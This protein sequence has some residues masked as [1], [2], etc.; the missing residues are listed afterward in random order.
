MDILDY[1]HWRGD[2]TFDERPY[3]EVDSLAFCAL[4][5]EVL[6]DVFVDKKELTL[7][8]AAVLFFA[9]HNEE[10]LKRRF[11]ATSRS[12]EVLKA[13]SGTRR[14]GSL[15]LSHYVDE[16][17]HDLDLQFAAMTIIHKNKWKCIVFRGTDDTMTGWKEDF[18]M[19]YR[20]E[21]LAQKKAV[22]YIHEMTKDKT[23]MD[24][25]FSS[26]IYV[27]GHSKGG[28][29]AIY[30]SAHMPEAMLKRIKRIDNFDGPGFR[31]E[32]WETE[33]MKSVLPKIK[34]YL[35]TASFYGRLF[36]HEE[37]HVIVYAKNR[38]LLQHDPFNWQVDVD[39]F[40][41]RDVM[42]KNSDE[43]DVKVRELTSEHSEEELE[44][45]VEAIFTLFE[46]LNIIKLADVMN[47]E[48]SGVLK[49]LRELGALD[50]KTKKVLIELLGLV[51][52]ISF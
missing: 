28:N 41:I 26:D 23:I 7:N 30:A 4:S 51:W 45:I 11:T 48:L 13:M 24:K 12:Y 17:D 2:L 20:K 43:A 29:L 37:E 9:K 5:Y 44:N 8:E 47:I 52:D 32:F 27:T 38:G 50:N 15:V 21:V 39:H 14:F 40:E 16:I 25:V 1:I 22:N 6:N 10:E 18:M 3:N 31:Q 46:H 33:T 42:D 35:P 36:A 34:T 19:L 49:A